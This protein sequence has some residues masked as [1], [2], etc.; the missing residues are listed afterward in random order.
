M[1]V[2]IF[3]QIGFVGLLGRASTNAILIVEFAQ[4]RQEAGVPRWRATLEA[5]R[6]RLRLILMTSLAFIFDV[7]PLVIAQGSASRCVAPWARP[8]SAACSE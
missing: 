1:S 3:T 6:L 8:S 7:V 2:A 4:Q 5:S